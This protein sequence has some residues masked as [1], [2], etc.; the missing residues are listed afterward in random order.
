MGESLE[1]RRLYKI[2]LAEFPDLELGC[3][4][5][6]DGTVLHVGS[7]NVT[8]DLGDV[9]VGDGFGS[10]QF[11]DQYILH[12]EISI[13]F[14]YKSAIFIT[15]DKLFLLL[16]LDADFSQTVCERVFMDLLQMSG[17]KVPPNLIACFPNNVSQ[18]KSA[19]FHRLGLK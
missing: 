15:N 14:A 1:S 9:F 3:A 6:D 11:K 8:E 4:K 16:D 2:L 13:V 18:F 10:F 12:N 5:I 17:T 19:V 7:S